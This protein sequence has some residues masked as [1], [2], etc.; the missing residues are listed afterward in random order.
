MS[1]EQAEMTGEDVDT[2]TDVYALG[3]ILYQLLTGALPFE[4][5]ELRRAGLEGIVR[6]IRDK[7]P[8]RPSTRFSI[9]GEQAGNVAA[10]R[11]T[12][13]GKLVSQLR[14]D[15]DCIVMK[16]L[17]KDRT[18][19]FGSASE[20]AA[21][22]QRH[23]R[24]EP[25]TASPPDAMDRARKFIRRHRLGVGVALASAVVV[26]VFGVSMAVQAR[27]VALERDRVRQESEHRKAV[28][29]FL[30]SLFTDIDPFQTGGRSIDIRAVLDRAA[31]RLQNQLQDQPSVQADLMLT[32][33]E[34]YLNIGLVDAAM[35]MLQESLR[36]RRG[37]YGDEHIEVGRVVNAW[38]NLELERRHITQA[39]SLLGI[40]LPI[41]ERRLGPMDL[42]VSEALRQTAV[43]RRHQQRY[44][45]AE[46]LYMQS[47]HILKA[48]YGADN[49]AVGKVVSDIGV[50]H[51]FMDDFPE[52]EARTR[53]AIRVYE[54][55][56][57]MSY[58]YYGE[59]MNNLGAILLKQDKVSEALVVFEEALAVLR[60][61]TG[62]QHPH[63][64][65]TLNWLGRT[66][67]DIGRF[68]EAVAMQDEAYRI[69]AVTLGDENPRVQSTLDGL[70]QSV[71]SYAQNLREAGRVTAADSLVE[72]YRRTTP[73]GRQ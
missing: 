24:H 68:E 38:G 27:R 71:D 64:A 10:A 39:D 43:V 47:M 22:V 70:E 51:Y 23:L 20:L 54:S 45:E 48:H 5:E 59:S 58:A 26:I 18:R 16:A 28:S 33:G 15:L 66:Y 17:E 11:R 25:V 60:E 6:T 32:L 46:S 53:Q 14:G 2:R 36:L 63:V 4:P 41:L 42:E 35:P 73:I 56:E 62:S 34:V 7:D 12:V 1:P 69:Y 49:A 61:H 67:R 72:H 44:A 50:L 65:R 40:A 3:V 9:M 8:P 55:T 30:E 52:A 21:D 31:E 13:P 57:P 19:R 37:L 29:E